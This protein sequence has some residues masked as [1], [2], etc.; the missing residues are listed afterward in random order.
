MAIQW[1]VPVWVWPLLLVVAA[2]A[3]VWTVVVYGR[4]RPSP[5]P[6]LRRV[7]ITLRATALTL[8]VAAVAAPVTSCLRPRLQPAELVFV[9]EDSASMNLGDDAGAVGDTIAGGVATSRW[10]RAL[11]ATATIDSLFDALHPSVKRSYVRGNGLQPLQD[12]SPADAAIPVP[13]RHGTS[14]AALARRVR[15]RVAGRPVRAVV[16]VSDGAETEQGDRVDA[17]ANAAAAL[18]LRVA[19]VGPVDGPPDRAVVDVR[20]PPVAYAGDEVIVEMAVAQ[21]DLPAG[22]VAPLIVT[23]RD[24]QGVVAADTVTASGPVVP[25]ALSF[26]PRGEGLQALRLEASPLVAERYLE[27]NRASFAVDVRRDRARV[28][29]IAS[30]PGWDVRFLALAAAG[31][32]RLAL[33]VA[34]PTARGLVLADSLQPWQ[35]PQTA[36]GWGRWDAVVLTGWSGTGGRLDW[37]SLGKAVEDGLGLLVLP[38]ATAAPGGQAAGN[39]PPAALSALLPVETAPWSWDQVNRFATVTADGAV[40]PVLEGIGDAAAGTFLGALPPWRATARVAARPDASVLLEASTGAGLSGLPALVVAPRGQGRVAW[41]GVRQVW[42]WA[43]WELPGQSVAA[44]QPARRT[45]RNLLVWLAGGA[46][47]SGLDFASRPGVYQEGQP[48]RIEARWRDLRGDPV[49]DRLPALVLHPSGPGADTTAV[50]T[51]ALESISGQPG[52]SFVE[53]PPLAPGRYTTRLTASGEPTVRGPAAD[54]VVTDTS[55]E[56]AQVRQ[57]RHRLEQLAAR[58]GG[59]YV[60]LG[61]PGAAGRLGAELVALDWSG[62]EDRQRRRFDLWSGW[63]F[64]AIVVALLGAE[65]FLRRRHGLL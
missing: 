26:R 55:V 8:L 64:V 37:V 41:L 49:L 42:E 13:S 28:L 57:D 18:P 27:N 4:T 22:A 58:A 61:Q 16:L 12:F 11:A 24:E 36:A 34:Y 20:H 32:R 19:G 52:A 62:V 59:S 35:P 51:F 15:E 53:L 25:V 56:R 46:G 54:L 10:Q 44:E 48:V 50:R 1:S 47:Q 45:L 9:V 6:R 65:W 60:D 40:H 30:T 21:R 43:F 39:A 5:G 7:L 14:L 63:P 31:E 17:L 33:T 23:L 38:S 2:G 3:I 29:V